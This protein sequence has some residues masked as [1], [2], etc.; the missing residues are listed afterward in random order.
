MSE[1]RELAVDE[2]GPFV[3][4]VSKAF[5]GWEIV[6]AQDKEGTRDHLLK[7][8][9][10]EPTA[11]YYGIFR[12]GQLAGGMRLHDF[13]MNLRGTRIGAGGIGLVAVHLLHK[14]QHVAKEMV[15]FFLRHY[16]E[17]A[18]PLAL[19]YPFRPDFYK[20]MG[21]GYG[22]KLNRYRFRPADLPKGSSRAHIR[23]LGP[24]DR[25]LIWDYYHRVVDRTHGMIEWTPRELDNMLASQRQHLVGYVKEGRLQGYVLFRWQK[26]ENDMVNDLVV[27]TLFYDTPAVLAELAAFL[28]AQ[29]DQVRRIVLD[30]PDDAF[31]YLL[32]DPRNGSPEILYD[33]YH[34]TN[35][36]GVGLMYRVV[37]TPALF[38]LLADR[39]WGEGTCRVRL[40]IADTFL[41]ENAGSTLVHFDK[42]RAAVVQR[43]KHEVEVSLDVADFSS[44]L[45]GAVDL[46][47]LYRLGRAQVS[48]PAYVAPLGRILAVEKPICTSLF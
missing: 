27:R 16:R 5:P 24:Q 4:I 17:R 7:A 42:G 10:E 43:G 29:A 3:D 20:Q 36:Q 32:H 40:T 21:F 6:T 9:E 18:M 41:P 28:H 11:R 15:D 33:E 8:R 30:T 48:D 45:V 13:R 39:G 12:Q 47:G 46:A 31:H 44:L 25:Q 19:L 23:A 1:I 14:K 38:G 35:V 26:G 2:F 37:D 22:A 34:E